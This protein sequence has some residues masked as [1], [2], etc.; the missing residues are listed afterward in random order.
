M[1][2]YLRDVA[3][4]TGLK[5]TVAPRNPYAS[6]YGRKIPASCMITIGDNPRW[7]RIY[8]MQY[9]NAGSAYVNYK[10]KCLFVDD[11]D[12]PSVSSKDLP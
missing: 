4:I 3:K 11:N 7:Y 10:G 1:V 12:L 2:S 9:G 5:I 6:G 8:V